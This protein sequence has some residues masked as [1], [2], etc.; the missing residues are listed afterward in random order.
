[1]KNNKVVPIR[2]PIALI[3]IFT[4][5]AVTVALFKKEGLNLS[6]ITMLY[7]KPDMT[8]TI[9]LTTG[10][11]VLNTEASTIV[12]KVY[13]LAFAKNS[14]FE[15]FATISF[16]KKLVAI[17]KLN[18]HEKGVITVFEKYDNGRD[19]L[20]KSCD[21]LG[22]LILIHNINESKLI[23]PEI[24]S[25]NIHAPCFFSIVLICFCKRENTSP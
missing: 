22:G 13:T 2:K 16:F 14:E 19:K 11:L 21:E 10:I 6:Y 25:V 23:T 1:M 7:T 9:T 24:I 3:T 12:T 20:R 15:I 4:I 8:F 17:Q 18:T 5:A